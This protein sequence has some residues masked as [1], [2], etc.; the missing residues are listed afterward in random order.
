[1]GLDVILHRMYDYIT[2]CG[3]RL[4]VAFYYELL[5]P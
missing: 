5:F 2:L 1:M 4:I 3:D